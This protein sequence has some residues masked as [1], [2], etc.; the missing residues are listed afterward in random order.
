MKNF[1]WTTWGIVGFIF[2]PIGF[3]FLLIGFA[4]STSGSFPSSSDMNVL[5][6]TFAGMGGLFLLLGLAM[7][8]YD[9]RRR[10]RLRQAFYG[11]YYVDGKITGIKEIRNVNMNGRHPVV[12]ECSYTDSSGKEHLYQSRFLYSLPYENLIGKTVPVYLDRMDESIG[13]VD[14]D[15]ILNKDSL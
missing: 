8:A 10:N 1:G 9:L 15:E 7:L 11:G 14:T 5:K 6:Y 13:Y 3:I 12:I 2:A 4:F